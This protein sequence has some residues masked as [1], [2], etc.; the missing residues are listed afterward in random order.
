MYLEYGNEFEINKWFEWCST[1][2]IELETEL[3]LVSNT[4][5]MTVTSSNTVI[6]LTA[7]HLIIKFTFD[8]DF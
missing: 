5:G 8:L 7:E 6:V 3:Q 1:L 4:W 2:N